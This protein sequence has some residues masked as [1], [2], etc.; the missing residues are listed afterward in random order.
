MRTL[1]AKQSGQNGNTKRATGDTHRPLAFRWLN[2]IILLI[3]AVSQCPQT[4]VSPCRV[5]DPALLVA[6]VCQLLLFQM[7]LRASVHSALFLRKP[8]MTLLLLVLIRRP[9]QISRDLENDSYG[10]ATSLFRAR[11]MATPLLPLLLRL[12]LRHLTHMGDDTRRPLPSCRVLNSM[13]NLRS[14]RLSRRHPTEADV[15]SKNPL[16]ALRVSS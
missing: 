1:H 11:P 6:V 13:L 7:R 5:S 3:P 10:N 16:P 2:T 4:A 12:R 8:L 15:R 14:T 9:L